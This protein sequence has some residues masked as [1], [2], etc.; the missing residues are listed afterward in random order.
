MTQ[1]PLKDVELRMGATSPLIWGLKEGVGGSF[2][3]F[4]LYLSYLWR[5]LHVNVTFCST[6]VARWTVFRAPKTRSTSHCLASF[7]QEPNTAQPTKGTRSR[8]TDDFEANSDDGATANGTLRSTVLN[9]SFNSIAKSNL[10]EDEDP[11]YVV[12][13]T[14]QDPPPHL[15]HAPLDNRS[16]LGEDLSRG[17]PSPPPS[18]WVVRTG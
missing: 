13:E 18:L 4:R 7:A 12:Y 3:I 10:S 16:V 5:L 2:L 15:F 14:T 17:R 8:S 1:T 9:D 6:M 11:S